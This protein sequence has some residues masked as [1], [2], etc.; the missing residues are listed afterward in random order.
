MDIK[1]FLKNTASLRFSVFIYF[2]FIYL[3]TFFAFSQN[4][5]EAFAWPKG[6]AAAIS[7]TFDDARASQVNGGTAMLDQY[8]VKATF[9]VQPGGVKSQ[10][11]GWKNAVTSGHEIANHTNAHPC[12]GN[13]AWSRDK[14]L[15]NYTIDQ[16]R[17]ELSSSNVMIESLL[18][19]KCKQFAYPCGQTFVGRGT[20]TKSYIPVV[21]D[22]FVTGRGWMN[23]TG[24]DPAFCD[25]SQLMCFEADGK[26]FDQLL[27]HLKA[28]IDQHQWIIFGGHEMGEEGA[29]TTR[30]STLEKL[31][32]YV[33]NP[34]SGLWLAPVGTV[35]EYVKA[36]R[37]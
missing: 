19:V 37:K 36:H 34:A 23:E 3:H 30:L 35:A 5:K 26:T 31:I 11:E 21:A 10:L 22:L 13:F 14:A 20:G 32:E 8:N 16:M 6:K 25:L 17:K 9:Y 2:I 1:A 24:N 15:E 28:A 12:T 27:P 7:L 33:Q 29:Q 4:T 18:G